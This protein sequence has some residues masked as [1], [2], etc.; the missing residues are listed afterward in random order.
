MDIGTGK[1]SGTYHEYIHSNGER[2]IVGFSSSGPKKMHTITRKA[3]RDCTRHTSVECPPSLPSKEDI[4]VSLHQQRRTSDDQWAGDR[5]RLQMGRPKGICHQ[6]QSWRWANWRSIL[7]PWYVEQA[8]RVTKDNL[9]A[10]QIFHFTEKH[11]EAHI[12]FIAYNVD[13]DLQ[14]IIALHGGIDLIASKVLDIAKIIP[15]IELSLPYGDSERIKTLFLTTAA[16]D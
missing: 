2:L 16:V 7:Q 11:I 10:K 15:T 3:L 12:C 8:F 4:K 1:K 9:E 6:H 13:K 14:R 5:E